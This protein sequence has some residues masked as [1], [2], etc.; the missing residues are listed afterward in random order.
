MP[1]IQDRHKIIRARYR[2]DYHK[3][4]TMYAGELIR[5]NTKAEVRSITIWDRDATR[6]NPVGT[7][8]GNYEAILQPT[9]QSNVTF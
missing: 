6:N 9:L 3:G 1:A 5:L 8:K 7:G 2:N 4:T